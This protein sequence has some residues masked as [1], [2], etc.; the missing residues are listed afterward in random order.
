MIIYNFNNNK[1]IL[2]HFNCFTGEVG[3]LENEVTGI[4]NQLPAKLYQRLLPFD[5][6]WAMPKS[7]VI[8]FSMHMHM[9]TIID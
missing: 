9:I 4:L 8:K 2:G 7:A 6:N 5:K 3:Q 1:I